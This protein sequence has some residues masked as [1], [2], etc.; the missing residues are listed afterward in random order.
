[1][2]GALSAV[3]AM[4]LPDE[5]EWVLQMLG[6][7]WPTSNEDKLRDCA[8]MWRQ[9]GE[10]ATELH[11]KANDSA[12]TVTAHNAGESIDKFTKTCEKFDGGGG[13]DGYLRSACQPPSSSC[14]RR[15]LPVE[16][17][18]RQRRARLR[19]GPA[20]ADAAQ[21]QGSVGQP[22]VGERRFGGHHAHGRPPQSERRG[23]A[24]GRVRGLQRLTSLSARDTVTIY[25]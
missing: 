8:V 25:H 3:A 12:R 22:L 23:T 24:A 7:K 5:L 2:T 14:C 1:M 16:P 15:W 9:F 13:Q 21:Q 4:M 6:Y 10:Q 17:G 18:P 19:P 20:G 11:T